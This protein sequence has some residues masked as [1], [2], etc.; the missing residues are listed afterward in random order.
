MRLR[1][2]GVLTM[3]VWIPLL[4]GGAV[5]AIA[6]R[7]TPPSTNTAVT[8]TCHA[9]GYA[10]RS[11]TPGATFAHVT[12]ADVCT[13]GWAS[14]HRHTTDAQRHR[15]FS[16]YGI[17]YADHTMYEFD[18]LVPLEAGGSNV[19]ANMWP[20]LLPA[21][22]LKDRVEND[23]HDKICIGE[24]TVSQIRAFMRRKYTRRY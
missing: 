13:R 10:D 18:H 23:A 21:A 19:D 22:K 2:L 11:C 8:S 16:A 7:Y 20:E 14:A 6:G 12:R 3:W 1:F 24:R 5:Y 4:I 17:P 9:G 15:V